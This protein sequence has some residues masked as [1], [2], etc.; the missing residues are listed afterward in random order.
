MRLCE[1]GH[2][3]T[4]VCGIK[5]YEGGLTDESIAG[6]KDCRPTKA[7]QFAIEIERGRVCDDR[8]GVLTKMQDWRVC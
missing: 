3:E 5:R 1:E 8:G 4:E 6:A 7:V 2:R